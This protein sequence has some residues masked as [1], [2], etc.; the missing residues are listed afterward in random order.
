L[1]QQDCEEGFLLGTFHAGKLCSENP[2]CSGAC[3]EETPCLG[4][5]SPSSA[6]WDCACADGGCV[7]APLCAGACDEENPCPEGCECVDGEC[8]PA[9]NPLP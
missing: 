9:E 7:P 8:A 3:D 1:T 4:V 6:G 5:R 2:C